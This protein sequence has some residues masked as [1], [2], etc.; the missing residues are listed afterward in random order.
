MSHSAEERLLNAVRALH[1]MM[2]ELGD[3]AFYELMFDPDDQQLNGV[4]PTT[5]PLLRDRGL[6]KASCTIHHTWYQLTAEGWLE[7][8]ELTGRLERV[9]KQVG[10]NVMATMK[11]LV[12]GRKQPAVCYASA[13]A[14]EAGVSAEFMANILGCD[15][16]RAVLRR[17]GVE[18]EGQKEDYLVTIPIDFGLEVP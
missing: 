17:K 11:A 9:K 8:I 7:G 16:I 3:L 2:D 15:F 14:S 6:V 13:I 12:K 10:N 4:Y 18:L 1:L 5:W